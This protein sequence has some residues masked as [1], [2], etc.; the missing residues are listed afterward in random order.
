MKYLST[1]LLLFLSTSCSTHQSRLEDKE[2][3]IELQYIAWG[4]DC[5]NWATARDIAKYHDNA[6]DTL[7]RLSIYVEPADSSL[8]LPGGIGQ[9][10]ARVKFTGRFYKERGVPT[11]YSSVEDPDKARVFRYTRYIITKKAPEN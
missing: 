8:R 10:G 1:L 7:A 5:A 11:N 2:Q 6:G 9:N 3:T 4:C